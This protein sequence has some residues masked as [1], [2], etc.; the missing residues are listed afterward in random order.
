MTS[1]AIAAR[2]NPLRVTIPSFV[3]AFSTTA[4]RS[5]Y[6]RAAALF[7]LVRLVGVGVLA[8]MAAYRDTPLLDRLTSWD[9]QWYLKIAEHGYVLPDAVDSS[10]VPYAD[11]PMA[12]FPLYPAF[13]ATVAQVP[14]VSLIAGALIV[15]GLGGI[16][17]ATGLYRLGQRVAGARVGL[18]LVALWA[19]APM[20]LTESMVYTESLF[21][22]FAVWALVAVLERNWLLAGSVTMLAGLTRSTATVLI[23]VVFVAA[24]IAAW[25]GRHRWQAVVCMVL[26][27][28]GLLGFWAFVANNTNDLMGW[29][30]IEAHGWNTRLDW[31][32]EAGQWVTRILFDGVSAFETL[33]LLV[34]LAAV[35]LAVTTIRRLPWPLVAYAVGV[36]ALILCTS[37]L[38]FAKVR[39]LLPDF[40]L[41][42]PI[43][44]GLAHRRPSTTIAATVLF[45]LA[46]AWFSAYS[47]TV[48]DHAI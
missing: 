17:A 4:A 15:S 41:L 40:V 24:A 11:A 34:V 10:G 8:G 19:G 37:G 1:D 26:A 16:L 46:G 9:G 36:V 48:W 38:P 23:A 35:A 43:A 39:F 32:K 2:P 13:S 45:V 27:P 31:G 6:V 21:T 44:F 3:R 14:G 28:L 25:R 5:M 42:L 20:A 29:Q 7:L 18:I 22:A 47:L 12:F 33:V 30:D